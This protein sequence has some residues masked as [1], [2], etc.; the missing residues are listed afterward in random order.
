MCRLSSQVGHRILWRFQC[1]SRGKRLKL[2][3]LHALLLSL[4]KESNLLEEQGC[5]RVDPVKVPG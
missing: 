3:N 1:K 2:W 5:V 4:D